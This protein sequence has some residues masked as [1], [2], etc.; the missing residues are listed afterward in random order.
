MAELHYSI[1]PWLDFGGALIGYFDGGACVMGIVILSVTHIGWKFHGY[2]A[3]KIGS[4]EEEGKDTA[5]TRD[6][7]ENGETYNRHKTRH[8]NVH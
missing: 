7:H 5:K 3:E 1:Y 6:N 4:N 2:R 8:I